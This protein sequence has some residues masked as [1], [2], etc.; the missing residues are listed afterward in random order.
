MDLFYT[1]EWMARQDKE[2]T[3]PVLKNLKLH[4]VQED[5]NVFI[6]T[7]GDSKRLG[8]ICMI[9]IQEKFSGLLSAKM[10]T[11]STSMLILKI[12]KEFN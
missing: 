7:E 1:A 9:E 10:G 2:Q 12:R 4:P 6:M 5:L 8:L 11:H 3:L